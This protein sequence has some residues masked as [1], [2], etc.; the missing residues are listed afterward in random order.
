MAEEIA[1]DTFR[2]QIFWAGKGFEG[3]V[4]KK[5]LKGGKK[6]KKALFAL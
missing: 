2:G 4:K 5:K 3:N 6:E 1:Q